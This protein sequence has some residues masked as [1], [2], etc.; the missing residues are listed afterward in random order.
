MSARRPLEGVTVLDL[1]RLL[2]GA[3]ATLVLADLGAD[4]VKIEDPRGG[5]PTRA[6]PPLAGGTSVYFHVLNRNKRSVTLDL[7]APAAAGVLDALAGRADLLVES[8]RPRTARRL[9]VD[10]ATVRARH[11]R[12]IHCSI[13]GFGRQGPYAERPAHDLNYVALAGLF[14]VDRIDHEPPRVPR[15]LLGDIGAAMNAAAGM[16]AA[17]FM[18]ERT[19]E[20]ST[21]DV[22]IFEAALSWLTFP[23]AD[24]LVAGV[25]RDRGELPITG[26]GACYNIYR[27]ADDQYV[28]LGA[29]EPKFW[30][31]F[32]DRIGRADLI[33]LQFAAGDAQAR[34]LAEVTGIFG[35]RTRREWL[36]RFADVDVC[37]TPVNSVDEALADP[38]LAARGAVVERDGSRFIRT[39]ILFAGP[40]DDL[41]A[42]P[43][44]VR[45]SP[46]LGVDTD[47]VLTA[48]GF[49]DAARRRLRADGIV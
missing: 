3:Y 43:V 8:F 39:P 18:R 24:R 48:A 34:L 20:G 10:A 36:E 35:S 44:A 28:A 17:L 38:H 16:L 9:G 15:M 11:P 31:A 29:L 42:S 26:R 12:L 49:D 1:T 25:D 7:R 21:V 33:P 5:D 45:P 19:G 4:V 27:T 14:G 30:K 46:G 47:S 40:G 32:C 13:T 2:P 23:A 41:P 22:P 6:F 37:L